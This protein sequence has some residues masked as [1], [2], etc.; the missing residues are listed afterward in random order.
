MGVRQSCTTVRA[1]AR[2]GACCDE[3]CPCP[4]QWFVVR[5]ITFRNRDSETGH[6]LRIGSVRHAVRSGRRRCV[7]DR[8]ASLV[9][10]CASQA[11]PM[12]GHRHPENNRRVNHQITQSV[13]ICFP[14]DASTFPG[15]PVGTGDVHIRRLVFVSGPLITR[16]SGSWANDCEVVRVGNIAGVYGRLWVEC[17]FVMRWTAAVVCH[18]RTQNSESWIGSGVS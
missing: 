9:E 10:P 11:R 7:V 15:I 16:T 4:V 3:S 8:G 13:G 12:G 14:L 5:P 1:A 18:Y 2:D 17:V 6:H